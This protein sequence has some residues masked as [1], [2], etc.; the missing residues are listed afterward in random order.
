MRK[1]DKPASECVWVGGTLVPGTVRRAARQLGPGLSAADTGGFEWTCV[2]ATL[3]PSECIKP[4]VAQ[5]SF[6]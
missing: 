5:A 4:A 1:E 6:I 3:A 2:T